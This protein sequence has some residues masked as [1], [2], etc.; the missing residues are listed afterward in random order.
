MFKKSLLALLMISCYGHLAAAPTKDIYEIRIYSLKNDS[1]VLATDNY[2]K[3]ALIPALHK[4]GILKVGAFKPLGSDTAA[5]KKI[6]LYIPYTSLGE[7]ASVKTALSNDAAFIAAG[8][9]YAFSPLT[10]LPFL[11]VESILLEAFDGAPG[12]TPPA[13][14]G[15]PLAWIYELRSYESPTLHLAER[16]KEM[17]SH[18]GEIPLFDRLGFHGVFYAEVLVG[19]HMPNLM[20]MTVYSDTA[21]RTAHWKAF[22]T[23]PE[24]IKMTTDPQWENKGSV[25]HIDSVLMMRTGYS[26]L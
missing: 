18:G 13:L 8:K 25:S 14:G 23:S 17:I 24:W 5:I 6:Y 1:Q 16:K 15:D 10:A 11:R 21:A 2:L 12:F 3:N 7:W 20:Y 19:S 26:D 9:S 4:A 22:G